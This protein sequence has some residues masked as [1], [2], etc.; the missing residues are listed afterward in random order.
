MSVDFS[1]KF[2]SSINLLLAFESFENLNFKPALLARN[3]I[4]YTKL[5]E[6]SP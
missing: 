6:I 2:N 3:V 5:A 1:G 4:I